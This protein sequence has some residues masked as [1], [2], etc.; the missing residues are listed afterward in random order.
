MFKLWIDGEVYGFD[1]I[2]KL[3]EEGKKYMINSEGE[4]ALLF[5]NDLVKQSKV[6]LD[7][8]KQEIIKQGLEFDNNFKRIEGES[9]TLSY[10]FSGGKFGIVP[11]E[12]EYIPRKLYDI[13]VKYLL[14]SEA[15]EQFAE[16][17]GGY[18]QGVR[19]NDRNKVLK[20][21]RK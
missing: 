21:R 9:S 1:E 20:V 12:E 4:E 10:S 15:I 5:L 18:P 2:I 6:A 14:N 11:G 16:Q 8:I 17:N 7:E 13:K 3:K 19:L